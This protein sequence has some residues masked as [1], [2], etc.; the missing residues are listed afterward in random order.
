MDQE[1]VDH[2]N[3]LMMATHDMRTNALTSMTYALA[4]TPEWQE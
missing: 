1:I 2:I 4:K 3:F